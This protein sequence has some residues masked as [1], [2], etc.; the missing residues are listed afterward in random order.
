MHGDARR[1]HPLGRLGEPEDVAQRRAVPRLRR[2]GVPE[3]DRHRGRRRA[4]GDRVRLVARGDPGFERGRA[5]GACSTRAGRDRL[6]A[7]VLSRAT[8]ERRRRRRAARRAS[9]AG[10]CRCARA[11]TSWAAWSV[12]DD[13]LLID[14]GAHARHDLRRGDRHRHRAARRSRA[15][16]SWRRSSPSTAACS[17]A[18]TARRS[19]SAASCCRAARAGTAAAGAGAARTSSASTSS[20]PTASSCTPTRTQNADLFWAARGAGPGVL[21]R[22][23]PLPPA[24]VS[25]RRR[26]GTTRASFAPRRP[27]AAAALAARRAAAARRRGRAGDRRDAAAATRRRSSCCCTRR[28]DRRDAEAAARCSRRSTRVPVARSGTCAGRRRSPRRTS[29]RRCRTPRAT[30]TPPTAQ[31]TDAPAAEL[32]PLLRDDLER[33]ADRALVLDLVRLGADARAARHGV[34]ARGE[35]LPGDVRDL[36]R[37]GRRRAPPRAGSTAT[38]RGWP[39]GGARASTSATPTSAAARTA[40]WPTRNSERLARD[41]RA[42][43]IP[44]AL[45]RYLFSA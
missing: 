39:A 14:L 41:P 29:R 32:A 37:R 9:A 10:R 28:S 18:G 40:S 5:S 2:R 6:P 8:D 22:R 42:R 12:R 21:R 7:A 23:H 15:A 27:R 45:R 38:R 33:A 4:V 43:A 16:W 19:G 31:W 11:G 35:R 26:C 17:P 1:A 44:T 13:A 36:A 30:A 20:P 3:R 34:L 24:H 25:R